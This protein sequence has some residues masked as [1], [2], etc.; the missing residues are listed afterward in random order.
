MKRHALILSAG[1]ALLTAPLAE[2][3]ESGHLSADSLKQATTLIHWPQ[4]FEPRNADV[5][6][7]NEG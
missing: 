3:Q 7:H 2:A 1:L 5:F 6:V 4:G